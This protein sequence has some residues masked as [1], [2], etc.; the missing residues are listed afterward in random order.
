MSLSRQ[1]HVVARILLGAILTLAV[2]L[3]QSQG[4]ASSRRATARPAP[5]K[6]VTVNL[7][8]PGLAGARKRNPGSI[9]VRN[10]DG[11]N[12]PR[13]Q[14]TIS[15]FNAG[16]SWNGS[17]TLTSNATQIVKVYD[18]ATGGNEIEFN[19]TSNVFPRGSLPKTLYVEG[20]TYSG[21]MR[22]VEF[23]AQ[24]GGSA[25]KANFTVLWCEA[26]TIKFDGLVSSD[27]SALPEWRRLE[28]PMGRLGV[29]VK[30]NAGVVWAYEARSQV[31][32]GNLDA[33]LFGASSPARELLLDRDSKSRG[34]RFTSLDDNIVRN[35][36][37]FSATIPPG[38]DTT[39]PPLRDDNE[40]AQ[41]RLYDLDPP[42]ITTV[43]KDEPQGTI[44]RARFLFKEFAATKVNGQWVRCS[45]VTRFYIRYSIKQT[46]VLP[47]PPPPV[48]AQRWELLSSSDPGFVAGDNQTGLVSS[49]AEF[50]SVTWNLQ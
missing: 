20:V 49:D 47:D 6:A 13:K 31:R 48:A 16:T 32:P 45:P 9:I 15:V 30:E 44:Y 34:Y 36:P 24:T 41:G 29:I 26:P 27:N 7:E 21:S 19:G 39:T 38:R 3:P 33:R 50:P 22:D 14:I 23:T 43:S 11:N 2:P 46:L 35:T 5:K 12:A 8:V 40:N 18:A 4:Q 1:N 37:E 10:Y 17:V 25:E 28:D 42:Q